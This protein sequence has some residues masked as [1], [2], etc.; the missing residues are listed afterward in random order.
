MV[1]KQH[2]FPKK[3]CENT[4]FDLFPEKMLFQGPCNSSVPAA[5]IVSNEF[6]THFITPKSTRDQVLQQM[7]V[8]LATESRRDASYLEFVQ[9]LPGSIGIQIYFPH[10]GHQ[11]QGWGHLFPVDLKHP[12]NLATNAAK[13]FETCHFLW[14]TRHALSFQCWR[15]PLHSN[16]QVANCRHLLNALPNV[17]EESTQTKRWDQEQTS[18]ASSIFLQN[19]PWPRGV[20]SK[21][22]VSPVSPSLRRLGLHKLTRQN[23]ADVQVLRVGF[24]RLV[25]SQ[26]LCRAGCGHRSHQQAVAKPMLGLRREEAYI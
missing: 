3:H 17:I 20:R 26:D 1:W 18:D 13:L 21:T 23:P 19:N 6:H 15:K 9:K 8:D 7:T 11:I 24:E 2:W 22:S 5:S 14:G 10:D 25:V 4:V 16:L 12:A